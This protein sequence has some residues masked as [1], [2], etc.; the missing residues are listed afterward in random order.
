MKIVSLATGG[1][2]GSDPMDHTTWSGSSRALC[3]E[4][5]QRDAY[6]GGLG[7]ALSQ[8]EYIIRLLPKFYP[9]KEVWQRRLMMSASY[10]HALTKKLQQQKAQL[11]SKYILQLGAYSNAREA[12]GS[13]YKIVSYQDGNAIQKFQSEHTHP[14]LK[15]DKKL[16]NSVFNYEKKNAEDVDIVL[17]TS[18]FLRQSFISDYGISQDKVVNVDIG[19]N[20]NEY[21]SAVDCVKDNA[22]PELLFI[23]KARFHIKG[24]DIAVKAFEEVLNVFP[25]AKLHM[26]GIDKLP[27]EYNRVQNVICYGVLNKEVEPD[28]QTLRE[29]FERC[30]LLVH[31]ARFEPFGIAPIEAMLHQIPPVVTGEWALQYTVEDN[32][33]G[34]HAQYGNV[35]DFSDKILHLLKNPS[36]A[37]TMGK[38]G[39]KV[40]QTKFTW[41]LTVDKIL[42]CFE[43]I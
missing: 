37:K 36:L 19:I 11:N 42:H 4:L 34:L 40:A 29:L 14:A 15:N 16:F 24:G 1:L 25:N 39:R 5:Q 26:V 2:M 31:P 27:N 6:A 12:F 20:L 33:T 43:N 41:Q 22:S 10:R 30:C 9:N 35:Q 3:L 18:E 17:T 38:Q 21:P 28:N 32:L 7:P 23:G 8:A 13:D